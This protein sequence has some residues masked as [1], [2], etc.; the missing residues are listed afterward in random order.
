MLYLHLEA[1]FVARLELLGRDHG[2]Q[3]GA[4]EVA[5]VD[6]LLV[7]AFLCRP[8][9]DGWLEDEP[10]P[11]EVDEGIAPPVHLE[12]DQIEP[13]VAVD[14]LDLRLL[15]SGQPRRLVVGLDANLLVVLLTA[16]CRLGLRLLGRR[17]LAAI[18]FLS[19]FVVV[20]FV[21]VV[22]GPRRDLESR[23]WGGVESLGRAAEDRPP[24]RRG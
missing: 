11:V 15:G 2:H 4:I 6:D 12:D 10:T 14:V 16:L 18:A 17:L 20:V 13:A 23:R 3:A 8:D 19:L 9:L 1:S 24:L 5:D 7:I 22:G 21:P